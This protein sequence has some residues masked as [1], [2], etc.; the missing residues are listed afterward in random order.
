MEG[1]DHEVSNTIDERIV[2]M[3]I[4]NTQMKSGA[5]ETLSIM[6]K[7]KNSL[8]FTG[9]AKGLSE[10]SKTASGMNMGVLENGIL[11]VNKGFA[12]MATVAVTA[13]ATITHKAVDAGLNLAKSLTVKPIMQGL[14]E[15]ETTL[16]SVQTIMANTGLKGQA[17]LDKVNGALKNLNDYSDKTI[18]NFSEMARNIGTFTAA[19]IKLKPAT[20]AIKGI[21][22]LAAV[23]GSNA[24]Q[25]STAMYQLSQALASGSVKLMDWNSVV[26]AGMGGKV[27]Q[28]ALKTTAKAHGVAVDS[29]IKKSGSFRDSLKEGWLDK[30][31]LTDTLKQFAGEYSKADL[32][33]QGFSK[34]QAQRIV[35]MGKTATDAATKVKTMSQLINTLQETAG[36]GWAQTWQMIFGD[37]GEAKTLFT[38]LN[39]TLGGIIGANADARNK[40][41]GDWKKLGGRT[42]MIQAI[43]N[44]W[45]GLLSIIRPIKEAFRDIFPAM[46]GKRLYDITVAFR[47]FTEGIKLSGPSAEALKTT[48]KGIFAILDIGVRIVKAIVGNF[49]DMAG[50]MGEG[51]GSILDLTAGIAT[52]IIKFRDWLVEGDKIGAFFDK[53]QEGKAAVLEPIVGLISSIIGA[54][55]TLTTSGA[56]A[57]MDQ[58]GA[59]LAYIGPI[60]DAVVANIQKMIDTLTGGVKKIDLSAI[61]GGVGA[62][63]GGAG[64]GFDKVSDSMDKAAQAAKRVDDAFAAIGRGFTAVKNFVVNAAKAV[65]D[66]VVFIKDKLQSMAAGVGLEDG[67]AVINTGFLTLLYLS[68]RKFVKQVGGTFQEMKNTFRSASGVLDQVTNNLKSMQTEVRARAILMIA[69]ALVLLAGALFILSKIDTAALAQ[70]LAAVVILLSALA[71]AIVVLEKK[72]ESF[73]GAARV[74]LLAGAMVL[75]AGAI[76]LLAGAVAILGNMDMATLSKGIGAVAAILAVITVAAAVLEKSGGGAQ[77]VA[78]AAAIGILAFALVALAGALKLYATMDTAMMA[79]GAAKM[80]AVLVAI[81]FAMNK[82]PKDAIGSAAA[83][84]L[85]AL[86]LLGIASAL[87]IFASMSVGEI[88]KSL[89]AL[90]VSLWAI[91]AAVKS[92]QGAVK[93][94]AALLIVAGALALLVPSLVILGN[95]DITHIAIALGA[96]A[97]IFAVLGLAGYLL[98]PLAPV[99]LMLAGAIALLGVAVAAIG[100]GMF[101]FALG[102]ASLA[103]SGLAGVAVLSAAI[104]AFAELLPLI[105]LQFGLAIRALAVVIGESGP[106]LIKAFN[107]VLGALIQ[108]VIQ[109]TPKLARM[110]VLMVRTGLAVLRAVFP[111]FVK[112]GWDLLMKILHGIE[113]NIGKIVKTVSKI[114]QKFIGALTDELPDL[115]NAGA[116]LIIAF[117]GGLALTIDQRGAELR[118]AGEALAISIIEGMVKGLLSGPKIIGIAAYNLGKSAISSIASAID[119]NSPS[120]EAEKLGRYVGQGFKLGLIGGQDDVDQTL[121]DMKGRIAS[122]FDSTKAE[123]ERKT[124]E[125]EALQDKKKRSKK[126]D[127]EVAKLKKQIGALETLHANAAAARKVLNKD[128]KDEQK[129]LRRLAAEYDK[130]TEALKEANAELVRATKER[131]DFARSTADKYKQGPAITADETFASFADKTYEAEKAV[132]KFQNSLDYLKKRG[133]SDEAYNALLKEGTGAQGFVDKITEDGKKGI[134]ELNSLGERFKTEKHTA[135]DTYLADIEKEAGD[136]EKFKAS[137]D[138]LKALGLD[139][140]SYRKLVEEGP[141]AQPF[142]DQLLASGAG[143]VAQLNALNARLASAA[144]AL[145]DEAARVLYQSGVDAA[146]QTIAGL[147][148]GLDNPTSIEALKK[149]MGKIARV[150]IKAIKKELKIKSPARVFEPIGKMSNLGLANSL[151]KYSYIVDKSAKTMANSA[152]DSVK[153][154]MQAGLQNA[155]MTDVNMNPVIAP[156]LDLSQVKKD[157]DKLNA[158]LDTQVSYGQAMSISADTQ[159][160]LQA[161]TGTESATPAPTTTVEYTQN[162]YSPKALSPSEVYRNTKNGLSLLSEELS[163]P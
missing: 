59:S 79:E 149:S 68:V 48:F 146:N 10:I 115:L 18:Y 162:N 40:I 113:N 151:E 123:I 30:S 2:E 137:L 41:L 19:G 161:A 21:A 58:I 112:T 121:A 23:S 42:E 47:E 88:A 97:G 102:L 66:A 57:F 150:M 63:A 16:N 36:S 142:V 52:L 95:M 28:E 53:L 35:E 145:G 111:D 70:S 33:A 43:K 34:K 50:V 140:A 122:F 78:A 17:G 3:K 7:L 143:G 64:A 72:T 13:L 154:T 106:Q 85:V 82:M 44:V 76:L 4:D 110:L 117:I 124:S 75:M 125:L 127:E 163:T 100:A 155:V 103:A 91:S 129:E 29:I 46:T 20:S 73:G 6:D 38:G 107:T 130:T 136:V 54:F 120:K 92:M 89:L 138:A 118:A 132:T 65:G 12:T 119:S 83:L 134:E 9:A 156:V 71:G 158:M 133:L 74:G 81:S 139:E 27:F 116:D 56:G 45:N 37:F 77:M 80:L 105:A 114:I 49:F 152:V 39:D 1:G 153:L 144:T 84:A 60:I 8:N 93:G 14:K 31:I 101:L 55:A 104:I 24:Q 148:N 126:E 26:N 32:I 99:I 22:N 25:A 11:R 5:T 157:T 15:Y 159:A 67:L 108:A 62:G 61:F 135:L 98:G 128:L 109:N 90:S 160:A 87:K 51:S 94:A 147:T 96:L 141:S 69:A 86:A 131:D